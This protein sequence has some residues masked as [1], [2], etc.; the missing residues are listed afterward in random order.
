MR[1]YAC[2]ALLPTAL[3]SV[4]MAIYHLSIGHV[5]RSTGRSAVQSAAYITGSSLYETRRDLTANYENRA[6]DVTASKTLAPE[7]APAEFRE[8]TVWN[9]LESFE[10]IYADKRYRNN[11]EAGEKYK[12]SARTAMTLVAALPNVL[13][14][15]VA[16][17]LVEEF[18]LHRFVS[19][20]LI[21]TY[22][23]HDDE[24]NP[25]A[26]LQI[27]RR[28][29]DEH[30]QFS[31]FKNREMC[32]K[33]ELF[34][35]RKLWADL[36]NRY[37]EREGFDLRITEKS[38]ADLGVELIPTQH[39][40]WISDKLAT[41]GITSRIVLENE[42]VFR[43]NKEK[44]LENPEL[45]LTEITSK[46]A[47]FTQLQ[48]QKAI[49]KR[50]GDDDKLV[51]QV[52]QTALAQSITVGT[53]ID[54]HIRYTSAGYKNIEENALK[55]LDHVVRE[56]PDVSHA[57][58][59]DSASVDSYVSKHYSHMSEEQRSAT[60]GLV[61]DNRFAVLIGR[62]GSGKT[63]TTIKAVS[64]LYK[65][66]GYTV[67][68]TS[69]SALAS[70]NLGNE[71]GI[72]S[73]TIAS[74]LF[75]WDRY[76]T[77]QDKFYSFTSIIDDGLLK[78]L[79]WYHDLQSLE[80]YQLTKGTILIVDEA[81]MIGTRQW[82]ELL[83]HANR[84]GAKVI[85]VGDDHQFKAIEAGDFF[86][87]LKERAFSNERL[88][89][90]HT[91]RRQRVEWMR[92]A[93]HLMAE[94]N[95]QEGLALYEKHGHIHQLDQA[96]MPNAIA[97]AYLT[98]LKEGK[99]GLVL[100]FTNKETQAL[101]HVIR[102]Q[103]R[104]S[105]IPGHILS[106]KD[107]LHVGD[108]GFAL[109][110]KL[111]F[112]KNDKKNITIYAHTG[113]IVNDRYITNGTCGTL[114]Q[115]FSNGD[116]VVKLDKDTRARFN[117]KT[118]NN[119]D[120]GY[121][122]T[123]HK[124]QGQTVD[125]ALVAASP[126]LD[127]K[128]LYVAMTRHRDDVHLFYAKEH[129]ADFK[130]F[131][132]K[133]SRFEHKDLV[134]DYTIRP[135]HEDAWQRV[136]E[137][138]YCILDAASII[139]DSESEGSVDW[140]SYRSVK[141]NQIAL[142]KEILHDFENH[143]LYLHQAGMTHEM[144]SIT[145]GL[146]QRPLSMHEEKAKLTVE[147]YGETANMTRTLWNEVKKSYPSTAHPQYE[148]FQE[149]RAE[150]DAL[151]REILDNYPLH[152]EFVNR[153]SKQYNMSKKTLENQ[154]AYRDKAE[155]RIQGKATTHEMDHTNTATHQ[156]ILE[157]FA[158][159]SPVEGTVHA[160]E[161]ELELQLQ[162]SPHQGNAKQ[163]IPFEKTSAEIVHDLTVN[164]KDLA[165]H[166][167]G[168]PTKQNACQWRY[169]KKGSI[170]I[171]VSGRNKGM[172]S[173]FESYVT[174]NVVTLIAD[175][176]GLNNKEAF[177]WGVHWLGYDQKQ[178]GH[179]NTQPRLT[180]TKTQDVKVT[181]VGSSSWTPLF[182]VHAAF[183]DL[184]NT[185]SLLYMLKERHVVETYGYKDADGQTLGYVV[186]LKDKEG[187]KITPTLTYCQNDTGERQ[188]RWKGF[189]DNRPLYGLD[190]LKLKPDAPVL[191]VEG[192]KTCEAA[193]KLFP[194]HAVITWSGGCGGVNKSDWSVLRDRDIT[195]W[196][197]HDA[198]GTNAALKIGDI[199]SQQGNRTV[200]CVDLPETLPHKWDL[201]DKMPD[202][203]SI[204]QLMVRTLDHAAFTHMITE[205]TSP[206]YTKTFSYAEITE[207]AEKNYLSFAV[208]PEKEPLTV[209]V[210]NET[211]RELHQWC[212]LVGKN[213]DAPAM[214]RQAS[215]TGIYTAWSKAMLDTFKH[216]HNTLEKSYRIGALA[217]RSKMNGERYRNESDRL[218]HAESEYNALEKKIND[219]FEKKSDLFKNCCP[220]AHEE[221]IRTAYRCQA[222]TGN[223]LS[224][225]TL[226][227]LV[228][229]AEHIPFGE[230]NH[231][232]VI[233]VL[234]AI[235]DQSI[236]K[237]EPFTTEHVHKAM[238]SQR[239][240]DTLLLNAVH[241][242]A[243]QMHQMEQERALTHQRGFE[244]T[245]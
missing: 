119:I 41:M 219:Q 62:A 213:F 152:R 20:G 162:A 231:R 83:A 29:V 173:N 135:E 144:L 234:H 35:T 158:K 44:I 32:L 136:H 73:K 71:A 218:L 187:N 168:K 23:I 117:V 91:I 94:L 240:R 40:G 3:Y 239:Y 9:T 166:F 169:G 81:G 86:R 160:R 226:R 191:V 203:M 193:R 205:R 63:T 123:T 237:N 202:G 8:L 57:L 228:R 182:P 116:V 186:R 61:Q 88:F 235:I 42:D 78:Q 55:S 179:A 142:G 129:F 77:A 13:S 133:L 223:V 104:N 51:A 56:N 25:H 66:A 34:I 197:D 139:N 27:S 151:A 210:A 24:G 6:G 146:K 115:V 192:E 64:D 137:Y 132:Q 154:V 2:C 74:W 184:K 21:V 138:R 48:L 10:D 201:A 121:A 84:V 149:M 170:S 185:P 76:T 106:E 199:L 200:R 208:S 145:I 130:S 164:I 230:T 15:D 156:A 114:E 85:A 110:D 120:F 97:D 209:F 14:P 155:Q 171:A 183:P 82:H 227:T 59:M 16:T 33:K 147:V 128:G 47:T 108:K 87:E 50:I 222:L 46:Q 163:H 190:Q 67:I 101:N 217:A 177:K 45:I 98:Q 245:L 92:D 49:Q 143:K 178:L 172:Y 95:I 96:N 176:L 167:L 111:V 105:P 189:G 19:E 220:T 30:G 127:A 157:Q 100:A 99:S 141:T 159:P 60:H 53:G 181:E 131:I 90:L 102:E 212:L 103:L 150:R 221:I 174:G 204:G 126:Y 69:L 180:L 232:N 134:K 54:G 207:H 165:L 18:A 28:S 244:L 4:C 107:V 36:S 124:S 211:Y 52:F 89:Q 37:L 79:D 38:F 153:F 243:H 109:G 196:P 125:F 75:C 148:V 7:H 216:E 236:H 198:A 224:H 72:P 113:E 43:T 161:R 194:G 39:R 242:G 70:E 215:L 68:G 58:N 122:L 175:Q 188:W 80:H 214:Q 5:S 1:T 12:G 118:Y 241:R 31:E 238:E 17:E 22:A 140:A 225:E 206:R 11:I 26:H 65:H 195:I 229:G 112:L 233:G 93:S